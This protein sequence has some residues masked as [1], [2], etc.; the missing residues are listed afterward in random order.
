MIDREDTFIT[1]GLI[2]NL[3]Y[4]PKQSMKRM[5]TIPGH[6]GRA[7]PNQPVTPAKEGAG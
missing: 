3:F 1:K 6:T 2:P 4:H 7:W 5:R